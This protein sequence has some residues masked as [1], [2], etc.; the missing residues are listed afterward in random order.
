MTI[1]CWDG[2]TLAADRKLVGG[3]IIKNATKIFRVTEY[4][5]AGIAGLF[6]TGLL[7]V[8]WLQEGAIK[9]KFPREQTV[10][11]TNCE[12]MIINRNGSIYL[13]ETSPIPILVEEKFHAI[14]SGASFGLGAMAAGASAAQACFLA[15]RH[16]AG[17]GLGVDTLTWTP[18][19]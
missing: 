13:Y 6:C 14:G 17:C 12:I 5:F 4:S 11:N 9:N 18:T 1:I 19:R 7:M 8:K 2:T 10:D 16:I 15:E 3:D